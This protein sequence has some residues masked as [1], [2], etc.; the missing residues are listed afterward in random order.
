MQPP[1]LLA[2]AKT[3]ADVIATLKPGQRHI[4]HVGSLMYDRK[5]PVANHQIVQAM[6]K[7][8][9]EAY[10]NGTVT[11]VQHRLGHLRFEYI[12]IKRAP[13]PPKKQ[14]KRRS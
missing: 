12:L 4:Y 10:E 1:D 6:A 9:W 8:V 13:E 2:S 3:V 7:V 11:L 5:R 14:R